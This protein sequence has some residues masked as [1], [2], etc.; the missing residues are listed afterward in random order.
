MAEHYKDT[1]WERIKRSIALAAS[2]AFVRV[3]VLAAHGGDET[4]DSGVTM[5]E[6]AA[7]HEFGSPAAGIPARSWIRGAFDSSRVEMVEV[8]AKIAEKVISGGMSISRGLGLLGVWG[9]GRIKAHVRAHVAPPNAAS[10]IERKGSSTPLIDT[11]RLINSV[12]HE[13]VGA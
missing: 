2:E 8:T 9:V 1:G 12:A 3:G 11:G 4:T 10:T 6:L 5:I 13:V 7:I